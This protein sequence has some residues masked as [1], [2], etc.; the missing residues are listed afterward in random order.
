MSP[1]PGPPESPEQALLRLLR[2]LRPAEVTNRLMT[3][4]D[5]EIALALRGLVA[6]D[7][8][9]LLARLPAPKAAR[10]REEYEYALRLRIDPAKRRAMVERVVMAVS[11]RRFDGG[12]GSWIAPGEGGRR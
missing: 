1:R 9:N 5:R 7:R 3:L 6:E 2:T 11:G 4:A 10:V 12:V 8:E